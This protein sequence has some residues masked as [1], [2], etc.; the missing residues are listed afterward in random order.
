MEEKLTPD[1]G[2]GFAISGIS[3]MRYALPTILSSIFMNVYGLVDSLFVADLVSIE[4]LSAVNI[5][6][7]A[8]AIALAVGTIIATGGGNPFDF[9]HAAPRRYSVA[10][11]NQKPLRHSDCGALRPDTKPDYFGQQRRGRTNPKG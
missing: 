11:A 2:L 4:A 3:L 1:N 6:G 7:P 8:L 10:G 5:V 9:S